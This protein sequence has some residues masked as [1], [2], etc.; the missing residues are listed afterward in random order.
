M[1]RPA[2]SFLPGGDSKGSRLRG[3]P[4]S[5]DAGGSRL[6]AVTRCNTIRR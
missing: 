3:P 1:N 4:R 6:H 5:A 2:G